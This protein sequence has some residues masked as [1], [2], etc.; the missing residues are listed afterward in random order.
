MI[1]FSS[2]VVELSGDSE[3]QKEVRTRRN[4]SA[5]SGMFGRSWTVTA[6]S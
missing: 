6:L 5:F 1:D 3:K 4:C 2:T